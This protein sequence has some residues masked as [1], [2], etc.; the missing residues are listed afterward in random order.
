MSKCNIHYY[1]VVGRR[2]PTDKDPKPQIYRMKIFATNWILATFEREKFSMSIHIK[3]V[4]TA[5]NM[6][7]T[8]DSLELIMANA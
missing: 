6:V 8:L 1:E 7:K 3:Y 4:T 2:K 5:R